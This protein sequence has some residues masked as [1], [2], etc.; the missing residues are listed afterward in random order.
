MTGKKH[1]QQ[2]GDNTEEE[3]AF[4][5]NGTEKRERKK[6]ESKV[7]R[8]RFKNYNYF[9]IQTKEKRRRAECLRIERE[10]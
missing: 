6:K 3:D 7:I 9:P 5:L 4:I 1:Q 8:L 2:D 10:N